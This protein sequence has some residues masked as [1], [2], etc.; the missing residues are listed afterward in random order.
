MSTTP[1]CPR[2]EPAE[3]T[4]HG[5]TR[6]DPFGWL[7]GSSPEVLA[8]LTAERAFYDASTAHLR[9]LSR[10]LSAEMA[11]RLPAVDSSPRVQRTTR[12][13]YTHFDSGSDHGLFLRESSGRSEVLLDL[14]RAAAGSSYFEVGLKLV[15][16]DERWLAWSSDTTGDEVYVLRFR[17]L[18]TEADLPD[19][20][21][22]SYYGGA[23]SADSQTFFYTVHDHAYRPHQIW[24]HRLGASP[25]Q[26]TLVLSEPD[27]RFEL[28]VWA[29]RTGDLV[30]IRSQSNTTSE[31]WVIDAHAPESAPRSVGG[32]RPGVRYTPD[33]RSAPQQDLLIVTDAGAVEGRLMV[34]PVPGP[35]GQDHTTWRPARAEDP[36]ARLERADVFADAVVLSLQ[37]Q[38]EHRLLIVP[39]EDLSAPGLPVRTT[40]PG[41]EVRLASTPRYRTTSVLVCEQA[42]LVPPVWWAVELQTGH[43]REVHRQQAPG[44]DPAAYLTER[45]QFP[46]TDQTM[47]PATVLRHRDTPLDGRAPALLYG[48]GAYGEVFEPHWDPV[49]P[50]LLDRGVVYVHTHVRGGGENGRGWYLD[51]KLLTKQH[52]FDDHLAVADGLVA[53][54]LVD[55]S[56]IA[57]RG[58]SAG[59]L[60]QGAVFSQR[61]DRWCAV[62]A[63]VP[64]VD[65]VTTM[66]DPLTPLTV[67]EWEEWGDPRVPREHAAMLAWS[68]YDN[69]PPAGGRPELLVTGA[70]HDP[71]V[72]VREPAKWVA[73][74]RLSDPDWGPR[75][76]FRCETGAGAH[77]GPSGRFGHL[78]YEAEVLAWV[79]DRLAA[80]ELR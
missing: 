29:A 7:A 73:A 35:E 8:H 27:E 59:G 36:S 55:A 42:H 61:P 10:V 19:I 68:P 80:T 17:D 14:D 26:D 66:L 31:C 13:Y 33:H 65:V 79:L 32:R 62:L 37:S 43:R 54:G 18:D 60:L 45:H 6:I 64:F 75:C 50:S 21:E 67:T 49:L 77:T 20:V 69:L 25:D 58:L 12:S 34:A 4:E 39:T 74:L 57:T 78:D 48:Y 51:G 72:M 28:D 52:T 38:C 76:L 70:V 30:M 41:G 40:L 5:R 47:V 15:S 63:E 56:R 46:S 1:P 16:P 24:R 3:Y 11:A 2:P 23:W 53:A 71:R 9:P 44:Y 22:R